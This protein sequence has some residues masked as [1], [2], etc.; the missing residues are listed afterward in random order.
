MSLS[1][2]KRTITICSSAHFYKDVIEIEKSLKKMGFRV[3]VPITIR[4]MKKSGDFRVE[5][6]KTWFKNKDHY[7]VKTKLMRGHNKKI[8]QSD[9][10]LIVNHEKKG[11]K[12][13]IGGN[14]LMEMALAFHFKKPIYI[15]NSVA[16]DSPFQEEIFGMECV[17]LNGDLTKIKNRKAK[18]HA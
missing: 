2:L 12:G 11:I 17:F 7:Y 4:K 10:V 3:K 15:L 1:K 18:R 13:Y 6:Y 5:T 16:E 14:V 9:A 8:V